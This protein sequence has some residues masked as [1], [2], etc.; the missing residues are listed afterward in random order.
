LIVTSSAVATKDPKAVEREAQAI[1]L[2]LYPSGDAG[3]VAQ[4][5]A[6]VV[7]CFTGHHREYQAVDARYH[8][9]EHTLQG[10]L[11][12]VRLL[13]GRATAGAQP[14]LAEREF[15][16]V[17]L[18]ILLHDTGYLK[19]RG[20]VSGTGAKYTITHVG[21]SADLAGQL[22]SEKGL[23]NRDISA[24]QN[25]IRCTGLDA[26]LGTIPFETQAERVAGYALA[27]SDLLGQ[28][29]ADDYVEKLAVL[30]GEFVEATAFS[31]D[32][33]HFVST[34]VSAEDLVSRTP[35]FWDQSIRL[36]LDDE[37]LGLWRFLS[38]PYPDGPN[39]YIARIDA[40]M[41]RIKQRHDLS[42][43]TVVR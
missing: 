39:E 8:D 40:N 25:M 23:S 1:Y 43:T 21:R 38:N 28:M 20:D 24:V 41:Q 18:A 16:L 3:F 17:L 30:Y 11:C 5:F 36:K 14:S 6:W 26:K 4:A 2:A 13:R 42:R 33:T 15:S 31:G 27:T 35:G 34:F 29:A 32:R 19:K 22:L 7:E 37:L 12:L 10:T 9:L